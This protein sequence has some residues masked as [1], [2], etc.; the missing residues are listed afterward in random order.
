MARNLFEYHPILGYRFVP[1]LRAR[2]R[3]EGGGYLVRCNAAGFR[4]DHET[5]RGRPPGQRRVLLFGDSFTAGEG[6]S[7]RF[8]FGDLLE[9]RIP[10]L[11]VLNFGLPGSGTDQQ[12][13]AFREFGREL[14]AD[15]LLLCPMVENLRRN[16]DR[17]RLTQSATDGRLVLRA[18]PY[19]LQAEQGLELHHQPVPKQIV[20]EDAI[21]PEDR[22]SNLAAGPADEVSAARQLWQG[23]GTRLEEWLPGLRGVSRQLRGVRWP[24]DYEDPQSAG[25]RLMEAILARW[26]EEAQAPVLLA[27][28]PTSD[29]VRGDLRAEGIRARFQEL[30]TRTGARFVD[31][32]P[33]LQREPRS[34]RRRFRFP[35]DDHPTRLGHGLL[36]AA[37][38][39]AVDDALPPIPATPPI[40]SGGEEAA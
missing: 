2:V 39:D 36:A 40:R 18:K 15:A 30:A 37:L 20:P 10:A 32:L 1:G 22:P 14:D 27:P 26:I 33:A 38:A 6:V 34:V 8:R 13:L 21:A 24:P 23:A 28:L 31:V 25:W 35:A 9:E 7:N 17:H 4:C 29:H 19:F 3:H 5:A 11:Q 12:Y 16:L